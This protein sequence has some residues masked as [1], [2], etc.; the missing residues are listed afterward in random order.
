MSR[1]PSRL[2]MVGGVLEIG[3]SDDDR[4]YDVQRPKL[5]GPTSRTRHSADDGGRF[6]FWTIM[7]TAYPSWS[8]RIIETALLLSCD[9]ERGTE[10]HGQTRLGTGKDNIKHN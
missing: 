7:P 1:V 2:Q 5:A 3:Q 4:F 9:P 8:V 10:T 6:H